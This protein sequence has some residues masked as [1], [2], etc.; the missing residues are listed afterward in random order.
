MQALGKPGR[1]EGMLII[2][3][4][5]SISDSA[6]RVTEMFLN[7]PTF[8]GISGAVDLFQAPAENNE[9]TIATP[10]SSAVPDEVEGTPILESP[11]ETLNSD[12]IIDIKEKSEE[13]ANC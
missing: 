12:N 8:S 1:L 4:D 9:I 3:A 6:D 10:V 7:T 11:E 13:E 5:R 2:S